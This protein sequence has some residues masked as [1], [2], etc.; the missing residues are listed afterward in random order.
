MASD[1][2][3]SA[4]AILRAD[5]E[6]RRLGHRRVMQQLE[7]L[8]PDLSS[9]LWEELSDINRRL[10]E[11]GGPPQASRRVYRR[12]QRLMLIAVLS[13]RQGHIELWR[14]LIDPPGSSPT[15]DGNQSSTDKT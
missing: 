6:L 3:V 4:R 12:I 14:D 11:L 10:L 8:E 15:D 1:Q 7:D 9:H 13:L 5:S 2:Q